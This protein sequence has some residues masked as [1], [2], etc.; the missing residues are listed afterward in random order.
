MKVLAVET[1]TF[2]GGIAIVDNG[3]GLISEVK[4]SVRVVHSE[5]LMP[6]IQWILE[7]SHLALD[8]ID[9][10]A[11]SIG[12]GS[13]TG[14]RI[15]LSTVKGL[16]YATRRPIVPVP[17]LDAMARM[18]PYCEHHICPMLDA[19]K[20]EVYTAL[21]KW[22]GQRC[23]KVMGEA[24]I[25]PDEC[26]RLLKGK[27]VVFTGDGALVYRDLIV[28]ILGPRSVFAPPS[29][30]RPSAAAVGEIAIEVLASGQVPDPR[31]L[32]PLYIRKS[33]A[34]IRWKG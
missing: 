15:G 13:F 1:A 29:H 17:T 20:Q 12:P 18:L 32:V 28:D 25:K 5:R 31:T 14:L 8:E 27:E 3:E 2:T 9:A 11:V 19:R 16:S 6:A 4:L 21:Y 26:L 34:E 30:M 22:E 10:F 24:A 33:E 7:M 23:V